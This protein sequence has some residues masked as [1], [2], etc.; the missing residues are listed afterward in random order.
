MY[1][2]STVASFSS[3]FSFQLKIHDVCCASAQHHVV[4]RFLH[5]NSSCYDCHGINS[6]F[7]ATPDLQRHTFS[8]PNQ[9]RANLKAFSPSLRPRMQPEPAEHLPADG[10]PDTGPSGDREPD[11]CGDH[12]H[13]G[14]GPHIPIPAVVGCS[15][16]C[17]T[18]YICPVYHLLQVNITCKQ[19]SVSSCQSESSRSLLCFAF[20]YNFI[21]CSSRDTAFGH[22]PPAR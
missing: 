12:W 19:C 7:H 10:H 9:Y 6:E 8:S 18:C 16:Y 14:T 15:G 5:R 13:R 3:T 20:L 2:L 4:N 17:G 22:L 1:C 11:G 21:V